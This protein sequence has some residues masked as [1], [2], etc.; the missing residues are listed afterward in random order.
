MPVAAAGDGLFAGRNELVLSELVALVE[1]RNASLEAMTY[2]WRA[3]TQRYPQAIALDDPVF[4]AMAAPASFASNTVSSAYQLG[5]S[6]K[7]PWFGKRELRG[8][9][10]Q[11]DASA[12]F[13]DVQSAQARIGPDH[14]TRLL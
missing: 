6:Q 2:A 12:M 8:A 1:A 13:H 10:A 5:G 14:A 11:S 9:A 4:M 7:L 3:A